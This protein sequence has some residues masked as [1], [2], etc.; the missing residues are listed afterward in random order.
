[1]VLSHQQ[2][3]K[4]FTQNNKQKKIKEMSQLRG[5]TQRGCDP[6]LAFDAALIFTQILS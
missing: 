4:L 2:S 3:S 5:L 1:M 6:E